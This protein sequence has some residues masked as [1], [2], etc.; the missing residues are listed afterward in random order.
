MPEKTVADKG[1]TGGSNAA[2]RQVSGEKNLISAAD[3]IEC[4]LV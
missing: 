4:R 1:K 2:W 3:P